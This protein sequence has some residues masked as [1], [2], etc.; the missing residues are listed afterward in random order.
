MS[1]GDPSGEVTEK[2]FITGARLAMNRLHLEGDLDQVFRQVTE[3]SARALDVARV[4]VWFFDHEKGVLVC[5]ALYASTGE[6]V[7]L[8]LPLAQLPEYVSAVRELRFVA[9]E[10]A[11]LD[12]CTAEL[13]DY[14]LAWNITS[15]LDAAIYRDGKV[16]G[17]VCHEHVGAPRA[18]RREER[19][20]AATVA[21]LV[22]H[23]LEVD[24]RREAEA[25]AHRLAL[26]LKD[27][28][29]LDALGRMAAGVAHDLNNL[30]GV[31][32]NGL[33][34]LRRAPDPE[35]LTAMES[36][37]THAATLVAQ[38]M[39]LGR[40]K[41]PTPRLVPVDELIAAF[42][43]VAEAR[44]DAHHQ[45]V[46]DVESGLTVWA[47]EAQLQQV[48]LN[49]VTNALQAMPKG[50]PVVVRAHER[51]GGVLFEVLD[52]G[53]GIPR[54]NLESLF[55]PFF[56]TRESG[57]GI[58]LAVVQQVTVLHGGE[59]SVSSTPGDGSTFRVWWPSKAPP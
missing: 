43:P 28:H 59:V 51:K 26:K 13:H 4:G 16:V 38:L 35:V 55:D 41:T 12:P 25:E 5:R 52:T 11:R 2:G 45:V 21:D 23:F 48:L 1:R 53:V 15:M 39:S 37:A 30:L 46:F 29:R 56:T 54:E 9:T 20:F 7:P 44:A 50:G 24:A 19:Q 32:T 49:L 3:I 34:V 33:A 31:V 22:S 58:G 17:V 8:P 14:L 47:D 57:S 36:A 10:N 42:K 6:P 18:W 40:R 27:A